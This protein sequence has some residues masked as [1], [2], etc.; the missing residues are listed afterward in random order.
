MIQPAE[1]IRWL[2]F[3]LDSGISF[4]HLKLTQ[5]MCQLNS[6]K[7]GAAPKA[8]IAEVD[9]C[10]VPVGSYGAEV[11]WLGLTRPKGN[12]VVGPPTTI[13][14]G[15]IDKVLHMALRAAL[16]IWRTSPNVVL[17]REGSIPLV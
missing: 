15:L 9:T 3:N 16:P 17:H 8:L 11:W 13:H 12:K 10:V 7:R 1:H 14:R 5:H 6:V 4:K 2:D